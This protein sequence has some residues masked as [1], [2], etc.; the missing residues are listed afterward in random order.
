MKAQQGMSNLAVVL[1]VAVVLAISVGPL[2]WNQF[3]ASR[4]MV[5]GVDASAL[6]LA[7]VDTGDRHNDNP[8]V[9]ITLRVKRA[10]GAE[11]ETTVT[12]PMSAVQLVRITP[13]NTVAVRID[14]QHPDRLAF[15]P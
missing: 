3:K 9:K 13:G 8:I 6:V 7:V 12:R 10:P 14:P 2:V 15:L 11:Y 5:D 4:A 1:I